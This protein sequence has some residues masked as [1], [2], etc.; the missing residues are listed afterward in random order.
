M[1]IPRISTRYPNRLRAVVLLLLLFQTQKRT[2]WIKRGVE[3]PESISDHMHRMSLLALAVPAT[4]GIDRDRYAGWHRIAPYSDR[5]TGQ[6]LHQNVQA[7]CTE[8]PCWC[9]RCSLCLID[10]DRYGRPCTIAWSEK[11]VCRQNL[12]PRAD[13]A[14]ASNGVVYALL[15]GGRRP[16]GDKEDEPPL[17]TC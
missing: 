7:T 11:L 10:R 4:P 16:L 8:C 1:Q 2:G 12:T 9:W 6:C 14:V 13:V 5:H 3:A 15:H 17:E